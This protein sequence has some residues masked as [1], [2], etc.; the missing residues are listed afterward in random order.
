MDLFIFDK[1]LET[2]VSLIDDQH[3]KLLEVANI[4]FV[5]FE[6]GHASRTAPETLAFLEQFILY[7]FNAEEAYMVESGYPKYREH[8]A[9]HSYLATQVKFHGVNMKESDFSYETA[10]NFFNFFSGW[11]TNHILKSDTHFAKYY[12]NSL[13]ASK[14]TK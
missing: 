7:H 9:D 13:K 12:R 8:Q 1:A 5:S 11:I 6:H 10:T 3:R 2:G 4:Y 14:A